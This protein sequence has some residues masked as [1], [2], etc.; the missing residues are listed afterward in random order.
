VAIRLLKIMLCRLLL[1]YD[2]SWDRKGGEP[3]RFLIEG[4]SV[5]NI[6]EKIT[7]KR[8]EAA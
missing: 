6:T 5:P 1:D 2:L 8:R 3:P 4:A 7:V